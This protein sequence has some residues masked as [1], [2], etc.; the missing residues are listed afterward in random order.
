MTMTDR[1][2][3]KEEADAL[4]LLNIIGL[5]HQALAH[6]AREATG[7][8]HVVD[9]VLQG[10]TGAGVGQRPGRLH[11][12]LILQLRYEHAAHVTCVERVTRLQ[13]VSDVSNN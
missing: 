8:V 6:A 9:V 5:R 2:M 3:E 7:R 12:L 1:S 13:R 11:H 4:E 10:V